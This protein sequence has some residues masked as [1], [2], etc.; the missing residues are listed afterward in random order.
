MRKRNKK[1][2]FLK[3][4]GVSM[5]AVTEESYAPSTAETFEKVPSKLS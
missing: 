1:R 3:G 5:T 2:N 4:L